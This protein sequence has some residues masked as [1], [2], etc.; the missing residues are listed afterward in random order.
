MKIKKKLKELLYYFF[1]TYVQNN[2]YDLIEKKISKKKNVNIFDV[3]CYKS[4]FSKSLK[5]AIKNN[6]KK[7]YLFDPNPNI[8]VDNF[9]VNKIAL[10]SK[11][12]YETFYLNSYFEPSGS[13]LKKITKNDFWWN[14]S[15]KIFFGEINGSFK[16][17][18]VK[19]LKLDTFCSNNKIEDIEVLKIDT[20]GNEEEILKGGRKI[21]NKTKIIQL[22]IMENK[23]KFNKKFNRIFKF[24]SDHNFELIARK[25]IISVSVIS[26]IR[27]EDFLFL[28]K[29]KI[30]Y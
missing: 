11:N 4:N 20:E 13:S 5:T 18:I 9:K 27:A 12:G 1:D 10:H 30:K 14:L 8:V 16:P 2:F 22:E 25:N 7:F 29:Q 19:T 3:G 26:G 21:L 17:I 24:L 15:R 28:K 23:K 6:N